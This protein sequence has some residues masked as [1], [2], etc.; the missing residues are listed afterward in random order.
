[1]KTTATAPVPASREHLSTTREDGPAWIGPLLA[2]IALA[3]AFYL[4]LSDLF[5]LAPLSVAFIH[6]SAYLTGAFHDALLYI[7]LVVLLTTTPLRSLLSGDLPSLSPHASNLNVPAAVPDPVSTGNQAGESCIRDA[8]FPTCGR[9]A[10]CC[11]R[12]NDDLSA[13]FLVNS[14]LRNKIADLEKQV[15]LY[16]ESARTSYA[17]ALAQQ[18]HLTSAAQAHEDKIKQI[19]SSARCHVKKTIAGAKRDAARFKLGTKS[20]ARANADASINNMG[21]VAAQEMIKADEQRDAA[22]AELAAIREELVTFR[23]DPFARATI[24]ALK[25]EKAELAEK[26]TVLEKAAG[27]SAALVAAAPLLALTPPAPSLL[28]PPVVRS[29]PGSKKG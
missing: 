3:T 16:H 4:F 2:L 15:K 5:E 1:M 29:A 26:I 10:F 28:L 25:R 21:V 18:H 6:F 19:R 12:T 11:K 14:G 7:L 24:E 20:K 22:K 17:T 13:E 23:P 9:P 27:P 8:G